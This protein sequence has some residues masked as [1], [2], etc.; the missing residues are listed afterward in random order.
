MLVGSSRQR[1]WV[2][3][4]AGS[5]NGVRVSMATS[6]VGLEE[7][8]RSGSAVLSRYERISMLFL[9]PLD[10]GFLTGTSVRAGVRSNSGV[11]GWEPQTLAML[12]GVEWQLWLLEGEAN[13]EGGV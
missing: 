4:E 9:R 8:L 10:S 1:C 12:I 2:A 3:L 13:R 11:E 6:P 7:S 5:L